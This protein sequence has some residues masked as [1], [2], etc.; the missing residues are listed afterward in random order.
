MQTHSTHT[1]HNSCFYNKSILRNTRATAT[2]QEAF[3]INSYSS[4]V[5]P[6]GR[7]FISAT[8]FL[9][10]GT[11]HD[12]QRVV[13]TKHTPHIIH[14]L[15]PKNRV[16]TFRAKCGACAKRACGRHLVQ[17]YGKARFR[18]KY[19]VLVWRGV[20]CVCRANST[21]IVLRKR[22]RVI[23]KQS[24]LLGAR[25]RRRR[26]QSI[27]QRSLIPVCDLLRHQSASSHSLHEII[28]SRSAKC[29]I[30]RAIKILISKPR[31]P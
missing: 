1:I 12:Y 24:D 7:R 20:S 21:E 27:N 31:E 29:G 28:I 10:G 16:G 25:R 4:A 2:I 13:H 15:E 6:F 3:K 22:A 26:C 14:T 18:Y 23:I 11:T 19:L 17:S 9:W 8:R 30:F 5:G